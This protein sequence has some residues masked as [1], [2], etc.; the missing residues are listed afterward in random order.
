MLPVVSS[1]SSNPCFNVKRDSLKECQIYFVSKKS[2]LLKIVDI[3][4]ATWFNVYFHTVESY[5]DHWLIHVTGW[6]LVSGVSLKDTHQKL[7]GQKCS[8]I[9]LLNNSQNDLWKILA[10]AAHIIFLV[11]LNCLKC[12]ELDVNKFRFFLAF[13]HVSLIK[14]VFKHVWAFDHWSNFLSNSSFWSVK[15]VKKYNLIATF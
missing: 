12:L 8:A 3:L 14:T 2:E 5:Y 10:M 11:T 7:N 6:L 4:W 9:R 1:R 13:K 15:M